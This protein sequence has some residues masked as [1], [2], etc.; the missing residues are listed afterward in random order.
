[1]LGVYVLTYERVK[2][3][4]YAAE[5]SPARFAVVL[6]NRGQLGS[7]PISIKLGWCHDFD[8]FGLC[9]P[10]TQRVRVRDMWAGKDL[11]VFVGGVT[12]DDVAPHDAKLLVITA[13]ECSG[14]GGGSGGRL[15]L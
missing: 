5:V 1:M 4:S 9:T 14:D 11:G 10:P 8:P 12:L 6:L 2:V 13:E 3:S 7:D 15:S